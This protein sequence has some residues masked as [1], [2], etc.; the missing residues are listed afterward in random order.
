MTK[1]L[2]IY[3]EE[4]FKKGEIDFTPIAVN[5]YSKTPAEEKKL[6]KKEDFV[7]IYHDMVT[8]RTFET[9]INEL[10]LHG[11]YM[12]VKYNHAGP[13]HLSMGQEAAAVGQAYSLDVN[14]HTFGSHRSHSEILAKGLSSIRKLDDDKLMD[15]MK[16]FFGGATLKVVEKCGCKDVKDLAIHFLIYGAYA[17]IF[18]RTTGFNKGWGGSMHCFFT[19]FGI[20]PNNAIVGGSGSVA[21]GAALFKLVN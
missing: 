4:L 6:F 14:D 19:P 20:Y 17:E 8:L 16:N 13:A 18:A 9:I 11:E 15:I 2:E 10:K 7:N 21:P 3:P 1:C 5:A 12:G